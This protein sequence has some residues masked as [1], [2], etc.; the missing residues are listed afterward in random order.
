MLTIEQ[1]SNKELA[2]LFSNQYFNEPQKYQIGLLQM[3]IMQGFMK[4][5]DANIM[6]LQFFAPIYLLMTVCDR[7][8]QREPEA[9]KMLENILDNLTECTRSRK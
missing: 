9:L 5:E 1:F 4:N 6:A 8:P 7:E 2:E 3:L